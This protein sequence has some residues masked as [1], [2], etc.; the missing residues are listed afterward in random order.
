MLKKSKE[1]DVFLEVY[2]EAQCPDTT[3]FIKRQLIPTWEKLKSTER[4]NVSIIPFGKATCERKNDDFEYV[5]ANRNQLK[6]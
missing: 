1:K 4:L 6:N 3:A 2:M 5:F